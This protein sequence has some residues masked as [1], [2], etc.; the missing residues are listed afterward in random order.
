M[1][2]KDYG[3]N[4]FNKKLKLFCL[5]VCGVKS[6][7]KYNEFTETIEKYDIVILL[8]T[9]LDDLDVLNVPYGYSYC[10]KNRQ[11]MGKKSGGIAL[12]YKTYMKKHI[13]VIETEN[14]YVLWVKFS[15]IFLIF[16]KI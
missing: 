5:N 1:N 3:N 10:V 11:N 12:I 14:Q 6:K 13:E 15:K 2:D 7:L 4:L 8:E 16:K 9:K